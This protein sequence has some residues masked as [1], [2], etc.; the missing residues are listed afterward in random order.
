[1]ALT[2]THANRC[3]VITGANRGLGLE[4]ARQLTERGEQVIGTARDPATAEALAALR[5]HALLRLDVGDTPSVRAF[6]SELNALDVS[7]DLLINNAG[8]NVTAFGGE[9]ESSH[10]LSADPDHVAGELRVN[11]IGPMLVARAVA[12]HMRDGGVIVNVSSQLGS[13]EVAR[14]HLNDIGYN[15]SKAALNMVTV[16]L[17]GKLG[18]R[19]ITTV[20]IHPGWVST[21]M[22]GSEAPLTPKASVTAMLGT[23]DKLTA[24]DNGTFLNWNGTKHPW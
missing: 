8:L 11:A 23:I 24:A 3:V 15:M 12:P 2:S 10:V 17:A 16:A 5:P 20:S 1:M 14:I 22:G 19:G 21:D 18:P 6:Q 13:M 7:V 9:R 4:L